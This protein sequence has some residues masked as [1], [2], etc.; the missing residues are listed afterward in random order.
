MPANLTPQYL[1]AEQRFKEASTTQEKMEALEEMMAVIPKHK[2]TEK[3]F[4]NIPVTHGVRLA[5]SISGDSA[6]AHATAFCQAF[7]RGANVAAP[8]VAMTWHVGGL[9]ITSRPSRETQCEQESTL[10]AYPARTEYSASFGLHSFGKGGPRMNRIGRFVT[11]L[12]LVIG[13]PVLVFH[14]TEAAFELKG[15]T[16]CIAPSNPGGGW[17]AICRTTSAVLQKTGMIKSPMYV[18]NMPGGSGAVAIA[19]VITK[20]KADTNLIVAASNALTFTTA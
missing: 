9:G 11:L 19:N 15:Q 8:N 12:G 17:D 10:L 13:L 2:G 4:E 5:E 20:R 3:L 16:E 7:E 6:F 14:S 18:T 1:A